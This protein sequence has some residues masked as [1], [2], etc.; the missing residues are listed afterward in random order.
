ML[1]KH[2]DDLMSGQTDTL[3]EFILHIHHVN[4]VAPTS[5]LTKFIIMEFCVAALAAIKLQYGQR[6]GFDNEREIKAA[7][8]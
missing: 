2:Y 1:P 7:V 5:D 8:L 3:N 6:Y 4:V